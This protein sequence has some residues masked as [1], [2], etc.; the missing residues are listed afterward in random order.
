ME[1]HF[2]NEFKDIIYWKKTTV[3]PHIQP[4]V[5]NNLVEFIICFGNGARKFE[6]AQ[7][8]QGTYWNVIEG[9]NASKNEYAK[10]H[11]ATFPVYLPANI[12][13]NFTNQGGSVV[14]CFGGTGTTMIACEQLGRKCYTM[15]IDPK[16]CD[17]IIE[18]WETFTGGKAIK[19]N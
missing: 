19:L 3:A 15:E 18:R 10:I 5:I 6:N 12:I 13:S 16:Y 9:S 14:D 8:P 7:F 4:G 2:I 11:K 17:V 1:N